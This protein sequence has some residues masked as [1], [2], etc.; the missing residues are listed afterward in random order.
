MKTALATYKL[1]IES[2]I[3]ILIHRI[4][5]F[6]LGGE[7]ANEI[8]FFLHGRQLKKKYFK[9]GFWNFNG[10]RLPF[11]SPDSSAGLMYLVYLDSLF[12][13]CIHND[14]YDSSLI[15]QLDTYLPEGTYGYQNKDMDVTVKENDVII[16]AGAWIGDF[17]AYASVKGAMVYAF[18]PS[19]EN[20]GYLNKTKELNKN[21]EVVAKGLG[22]KSEISFFSNK[23]QNSLIYQI[24]NDKTNSEKIEVTTIDDFVSENKLG[25]V[26]FIKA[27]IEGFERNMLTGAKET[28]KRF[29][30]KLAICTYHLPDDPEVLAKIILDA[31]PN[32]IIVQKRK[33]LYAMVKK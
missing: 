27:D 23:L 26:D 15:D 18:E 4:N 10:I 6:I 2:P 17:S 1:K 11:Y 30:P 20:V 8:K 14:N 12:V 13:Y 21:I 24:T 7:K 25:S 28:L 9:D 19:E 33:K 31:N 5:K 3:D 29:G 22:D 16:D 32:Y